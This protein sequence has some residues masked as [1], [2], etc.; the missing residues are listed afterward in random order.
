[1]KKLLLTLLIIN[2]SFLIAFSQ[3]WV[4]MMKDQNANVHDVQKAF[5]AWQATHPDVENVKPGAGENE[6][7]GNY[8]QFKRWE[9]FMTARTY[10][11]GNRP[12]PGKIAEEYKNFLGSNTHQV[13]NI[14]NLANWTYTGNSNPPPAGP[15]GGYK[16]G[17]G[18]VNY[19]RFMPGNNNII[20]ACCPTGGLWE[21][22]NGGTTWA[23]KTD[24][25]ADMSVS[26]VAISPTNTNIMYVSIG[27]GDGIFGG[28]TTLSTTG[29]LKSTDGGNTWN[30]TGLSYPQAATG[31]LY[32]TV[33]QLLI[34]S[35]NTSVLL[36]GTSFGLFRTANGGTNWT[37]VDT[38]DFRTLECEPFHSN[39]IYAGT[40]NG[41]F[42]RSA[43]TGK[44][45]SLISAGI[46]S[47]YTFQNRLKVAVSPADSSLVYLV[48]WTNPGSAIYL[49]RDA[50][51]TFTQQSTFDPIGSQGWYDIG[52]NVSPTNA[53][54][55]LAGGLD[56]YVSTDSGKTWTEVSSW[57]ATGYP[58]VHADVHCISWLPGS[59]ASYFVSSDGGFFRYDVANPGIWNDLSN[60][61]A[62]AEMYSV[63]PSGLTPDLWIT[64]WQD[65]GIN[66]SSPSW[67]QVYG[68]DGMIAFIDYSND[69]VWYA[70]NYSGDFKISKNMGNSWKGITP[71]RFITGPWV[72]RWMQDPM[73]PKTIYGG[74]G[75]LWESNNQGT[76]WKN[77]CNWGNSSNDIS[78][79]AVDGLNDQVIYAANAGQ[80][81]RT[82][83][84]GVTWINITAGLPVGSAG[85]SAIAIDPA[86]PEHEWVAFSGYVATAKVFYTSDSGATWTNISAGL[87]NLP[88]NCLLFQPGSAEGVYAGTDAGVYYCDAFHPWISYNTGLP[89]VIINDLKYTAAPKTIIAAT[90]GRGVWSSPAYNVT[91]I[92]EQ[93]A[94][95]FVKVFP[96]PSSGIFN[97]QMDL[98][99]GGQYTVG[100]WNMLGQTMY[101]SKIKVNGHY[102]GTVDLSSFAKGTYILS[103]YGQNYRT[104]KKI[105]VN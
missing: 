62:I 33:N 83:N 41:Q 57:T 39:I 3:D 15:K 20:F 77:I 12:V 80:I 34:D 66:I 53:D 73:N 69:S 68:G 72:T 10:P 42:Y 84:N 91:G 94:D 1:M 40:F 93:S 26:D 81:E 65:N 60:N 92:N 24:Q 88:V 7:D 49:S 29:V 89:N 86:N 37:L 54:S 61:L 30:P 105:V 4:S 76:T 14:S 70:E 99:V 97:L 102:N 18:R 17:D 98:P 19:F 95:N 58:Y 43:D 103:V 82:Y 56:N 51:Q 9:W 100:V 32:Q 79:I 38:G 46:S 78:A 25:L 31:P 48:K 55:L 59:G 28:Y 104:E 44:T 23:T 45:W 90:Y 63:G 52:F 85:I 16:G 64:G 67:E 96:N 74:Y 35:N 36:A 87:P 5:Y 101:N 2:S 75:D 11:S 21:T 22:T 6:G 50:G 47:V 8:E 13:S 27:D 71:S